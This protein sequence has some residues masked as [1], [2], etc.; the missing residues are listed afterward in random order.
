M[1]KNYPYVILKLR[2]TEVTFACEFWPFFAKVYLTK[3]LQSFI[4]ESL[5]REIFCIPQF[6]KVYRFSPR[7]SF[8]RESFSE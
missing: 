2:T 8:S 3:N 6:A 7:E 1:S 4:R 5:S